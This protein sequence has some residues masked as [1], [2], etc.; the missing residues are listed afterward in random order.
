MNNSLPTDLP[1]T[2]LHKDNPDFKQELIDLHQKIKADP[3]LNDTTLRTLVHKIVN[4]TIMNHVPLFSTLNL[5][6][7]EGLKSDSQESAYPLITHIILKNQDSLNPAMSSSEMTSLILKL[8]PSINSIGLYLLRALVEPINVLDNGKIKE[9]CASQFLDKDD[10][11]LI[12]KN[13]H[14]NSQ[15]NDV[16]DSDIFIGEYQ[17]EFKLK[18][19]QLFELFLKSNLN[20]MTYQGTTF[21]AWI[22]D[23]NKSAKLNLFPHH[24]EE[25]IDQCDLTFIGHSHKQNIAMFIAHNQKSQNLNVSADKFYEI[26]LKSNIYQVSSNGS[27]IGMLIAQNNKDLKLNHEQLIDIFTRSS[28]ENTN[29]QNMNLSLLIAVNN[30]KQNLNLSLDE[31]INLL[32][33]KQFSQEDIKV[34]SSIFYLFNHEENKLSQ[35]DI[36]NKFYLMEDKPTMMKAMIKT[37]QTCEI[38]KDE[39]NHLYDIFILRQMTEQSHFSNKVKTL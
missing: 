32:D 13:C 34:H 1:Y 18:P 10:L 14:F 36:K 20:K 24:I 22:L 37:L 15:T 26:L 4:K 12:L 21:G 9:V 23:N 27:N 31:Y 7:A 38:K 33:L 2:P 6:S 16:Y 19:E 17:I 39:F 11:F 30:K 29:Y 25:L 8:D 35:E 28:F 5:L 3:D